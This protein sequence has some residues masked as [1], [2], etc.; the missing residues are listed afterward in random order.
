MST[1]MF[2]CV[3]W[4]MLHK[5]DVFLPLDTI[6][7]THVFSCVWLFATAWTVAHQA[8]LS[9]GFSRIEFKSAQPFPSPRDSPDPGIKLA[10]LFFFFCLMCFFNLFI[11]LFIFISLLLITLQYCSGFCH[12]LKWI[13]HGFTCVPH[14]D[15]HSHLSLHPIPLGL[16]SVPGL[17]A[18]LMHPTWA[19]NL[20]FLSLLHWKANSL[21]LHHLGSA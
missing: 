20:Q 13:S 19:A 10:I 16:L 9:M 7:C 17:S 1:C 18:C 2:M 12:T 3:Y 8:P 21:P 14:P 4:H 15:P 5:R 6:V 11:Y